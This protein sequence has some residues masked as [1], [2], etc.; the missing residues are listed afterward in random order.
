MAGIV[1][2]VKFTISKRWTHGSSVIKTQINT[3]YGRS[4]SIFRIIT[5]DHFIPWF[6]VPSTAKS[7][8]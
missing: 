4:L 8:L 6:Y 1:G 5:D 7:L 2:T 3:V